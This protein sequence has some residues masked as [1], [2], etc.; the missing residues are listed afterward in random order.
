MSQALIATQP[1]VST[2]WVA[3]N[4]GMPG[5]RLVEIDVDMST[6]AGNGHLPNAVPLN[7]TSQLQDQV[8]RD[9][10][11]KENFEALLSNAGITNRDHVV[12]Y[13]DQNNW[14]A[15]YAFWL[16]KYYGH[17]NVSPMNGGR[18]RWELDGRGFVNEIPDFPRSD[19]RVSQINAHVCADRQFIMRQ[20]DRRSNPARGGALK[21][22]RHAPTL[23]GIGSHYP[24][25]F[26]DSTGYIRFPVQ[27]L[28]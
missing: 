19:Y 18:K 3:K 6:C 23:V 21:E 4:L 12:I 2:E 27:S 17:E 1:L 16:F 13:G 25:Q 24:V 14:F 9:I 11:S 10:I 8:S 20:P 7:W 26:G 5:V 22:G 28:A 15:A